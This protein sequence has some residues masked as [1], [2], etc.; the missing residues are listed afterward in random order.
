MTSYHVIF[1]PGCVAFAHL[2]EKAMLISAGAVEHVWHRGDLTH[3]VHTVLCT[4]H[5][6]TLNEDPTWVSYMGSVAPR[7]SARWLCCVQVEGRFEV[8]PLN[9]P[10]LSTNHKAIWQATH[11]REATSLPLCRQ[12]F[13]CLK[14]TAILI[15]PTWLTSLDKPGLSNFRRT[16]EKKPFLQIEAK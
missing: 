5:R 8:N 6:L 2:I 11:S 1:L 4:L 12:S 15:S 3:S 16:A 14:H 7:P 13:S 10:R 9:D